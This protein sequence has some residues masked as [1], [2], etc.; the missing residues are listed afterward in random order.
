MH[1]GSNISRLPDIYRHFPRDI[2]VVRRIT[3]PNHPCH[4]RF[5][6]F[7]ARDLGFPDSR[8]IC[9]PPCSHARGYKRHHF[10]DEITALLHPDGPEV[11]PIAPRD[12]ALLH[13]YVGVYNVIM[14]YTGTSGNGRNSADV[15]RLH[16]MAHG[17]QS[18]Y[19]T[20][21]CHVDNITLVGT[22]HHNFRVTVTVDG[23]FIGNE[24]RFIN[25]YRGIGTQPNVAFCPYEGSTP[26]PQIGIFLI[27]PVAKGEEIL[28][29]YG[30]DFFEEAELAGRAQQMENVRL[31]ELTQFRALLA[32]G[33]MKPSTAAAIVNAGNR[34]YPEPLFRIARRNLRNYRLWSRSQRKIDRE[35]D[36]AFMWECVEH[37]VE[38]MDQWQ[39]REDENRMRLKALF[40]I[41]EASDSEEECAMRQRKRKKKSK[42]ADTTSDGMSTPRDFEGDLTS[43]TAQ[44]HVS[45]NDEDS[46]DHACSPAASDA[47][48][49]DGTSRAQ[50]GDIDAQENVEEDIRMALEWLME[51][52]RDVALAKRGT[53]MRRSPS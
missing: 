16:S 32:R 25:D 26:F 42:L 46:G 48:N 33:L 31:R 50:Q 3:D 35:N 36:A 8:F 38:R 28:I 30:K 6:L 15:E 11:M 34:R 21:V 19:C 2:F 43:P 22:Q 13:R 29:Y 7:A 45:G 39:H 49:T 17:F 4:G 12:N 20:D 51:C 1:D 14:E 37:D 53:S 9:A 24:T 47:M 23:Q 10:G 52:E 18:W 40:G 27:R 44:Q 5:G 41:E